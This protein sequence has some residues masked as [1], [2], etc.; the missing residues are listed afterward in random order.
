MLAKATRHELPP[1][2]D[3]PASHFGREIVP[4][5]VE[6]GHEVLAFEPSRFEEEA[7]TSLRPPFAGVKDEW[8]MIRS[9]AR[10]RRERAQ[11]EKTF[12]RWRDENT[13]EDRT[14]WVEL[15]IR[16]GKPRPGARNFPKSPGRNV[17]VKKINESLV[18]TIVVLVA[19]C[20]DKVKVSAHEE[21]SVGSG[22]L[23]RNFL[24][25]SPGSPMI[26]RSVNP[27]DRHDALVRPIEDG[28]AKVEL[29]HIHHSN[30][31]ATVA[32][33]HEHAPGMPISREPAPEELVSH[34]QAA[35][36]QVCEVLLDCFLENHYV[37]LVLTEVILQESPSPPTTEP[38]DIPE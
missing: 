32:D 4:D 24:K 30:L 29:T 12:Q 6:H 25:E 34:F 23:G 35:E 36:F 9:Q 11:R 16:P 21:G 10:F 38:P 26:R 5:V 27:N 28:G 8:S 15:A 19:S 3:I 22:H 20:P 31:K 17:L 2:N 33:S 37:N 1:V 18:Q 13:V 14:N 7:I